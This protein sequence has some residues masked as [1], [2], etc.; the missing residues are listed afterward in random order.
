MLNRSSV[1]TTEALNIV[2]LAFDIARLCWRWRT[3]QVFLIL[4]KLL[5]RLRLCHPYH[6]HQQFNF[7]LY[8]RACSAEPTRRADCTP[9]PRY[10][11]MCVL[12]HTEWQHWWD[13]LALHARGALNTT[14]PS[15]EKSSEVEVTPKWTHFLQGEVDVFTELCTD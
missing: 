1:L 8:A 15:E 4:S 2:L 13:G 5:S 14:R 12:G 9:T 10:S 6:A 11:A 3:S 7:M